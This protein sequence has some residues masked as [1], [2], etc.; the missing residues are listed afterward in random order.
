MRAVISWLV[1]ARPSKARQIAL[2]QRVQGQARLV[3]QQDGALVRP[4]ALDEEHQVETEKPLQPVLRPS[5]S[6]APAASRPRPRC[7]SG[8]RRPETER[9]S[10]PASTSG[11][12]CAS[13]PSPQQAAGSPLLL[14]RRRRRN[15]GLLGRRELAGVV[16]AFLRAPESPGLSLTKSNSILSVRALAASLA[17]DRS[18]HVLDDVRQIDFCIEVTACATHPPLQAAAS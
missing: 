6:M 15:L 18:G 10:C 12:T 8:C 1:S 7:G 16:R 3:Q 4:H 11:R 17:P 9:R 5:S 13:D 2:C 14:L